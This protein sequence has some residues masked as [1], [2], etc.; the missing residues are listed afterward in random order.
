MPFSIPYIVSFESIKSI[1]TQKNWLYVN[2]SLK[3]KCIDFVY[4]ISYRYL[5][6]GH[7]SNKNRKR[8]QQT[9][10]NMFSFQ[11]NDSAAE[12]T[13]KWNDNHRSVHSLDWLK[14]R[15]FDYANRRDYLDSFYRPKKTLWNKDGYSQVLDRYKFQDLMQEN[16]GTTV[17]SSSS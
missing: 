6:E 15:C 12:L 10:K 3:T 1:Q 14:E 17:H 9:N 7:H 8:K 2:T 4:I 5:V 13:I 11:F 16:E